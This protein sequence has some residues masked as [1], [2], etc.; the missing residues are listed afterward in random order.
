MAAQSKNVRANTSIDISHV[1]SY[2]QHLQV[3][4]L[5]LPICVVFI[6]SFSL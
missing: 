6:A 2:H 5:D 1:R 3:Q 4:N